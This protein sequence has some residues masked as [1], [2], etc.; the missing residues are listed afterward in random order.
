LRPHV[1]PA[2]LTRAGIAV[3]LRTTG[4]SG[5]ALLIMSRS[6]FPS[7]VGR[8]IAGSF[9]WCVLACGSSGSSLKD[10]APGGGS[11]SVFEDGGAGGYG[12]IEERENGGAASETIAEA[13]APPAGSAGTEPVS[14]LD[15]P[16]TAVRFD[17]GASIEVEPSTVTEL[18]L[19]VE[20]AAV[21]TV[22]VDLLGDSFDASVNS[23]TLYTDKDGKGAIVVTAPTK[24]TRFSVRATV[25]GAM[26]T[27]LDISVVKVSRASLYVDGIYDGSRTVDSWTLS[28][29]PNTTCSQLLTL[30]EQPAGISLVTT[31]PLPILKDRLAI[32]QPAAISLKGDAVVS[33]C[34]EMRALLADEVAHITVP[35][36][37]L[38]LSLTDVELPASLGGDGTLGLVDG[39]GDSLPGLLEALI[40]GKVRDVTALLDAMALAATTD[41]IRQELGRLRTQ[42]IWDTVLSN[43]L[44][45]NGE[46]PLRDTVRSWVELGTEMFKGPE[47][48]ELALALAPTGAT[49]HV[50][51][52]RVASLEPEPCGVSAE[53][54][55][56][57]ATE[58]Q[59]RLVWSTKLTWSEGALLGCLAA[60]SASHVFPMATTV[61]RALDLTID[62]AG[63]GTTL[64]G[65]GDSSGNAPVLCGAACIATLCQQALESMWTRGL[66]AASGDSPATMTVS[67]AGTLRVNAQ[68]EP[69]TT[70][71]TWV[72]LLTTPITSVSVSGVFETP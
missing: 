54:E 61:P 63:I 3:P 21:H 14:T 62:C 35:L 24:A 30:A 33:G 16:V 48:F 1:I 43:Q 27:Q 10:S 32:A 60:D 72:G 34:S 46:Q 25:D 20:P 52:R 6:T 42:Q 67:A 18:T 69:E 15:P 50:T 13:G 9:L 47:A 19:E 45:P 44:S 66:L 55:L 4:P 38:P 11:D 59:D 29:Y 65:E 12:G 71:G 36:T 5:L 70:S 31:E 37:D 53:A 58:P 7:P 26:E 17:E 22:A 56:S 39:V 23:S 41:D 49:P 64:A 40:D 68:A 28:I 57:Q 2:H 8:L 51:V